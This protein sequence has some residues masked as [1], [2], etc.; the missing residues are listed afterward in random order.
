[1]LD[2]ANAPTKS[3]H[4]LGDVSQCYFSDSYNEKEMKESY[5]DHHFEYKED[6][7]H[8]HLCESLSTVIVNS[9]S[10]LMKPL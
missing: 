9:R 1:M 2:V 4:Q 5:D 7:S 8:E 3:T 10:T 6:L